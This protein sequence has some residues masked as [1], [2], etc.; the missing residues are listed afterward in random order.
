MY[1]IFRGANYSVTPSYWLLAV[2]M[3]PPNIY[4]KFHIYEQSKISFTNLWTGT[5]CTLHF[6]FWLVPIILIIILLSPN[7]YDNDNAPGTNYKNLISHCRVN[8]IVLEVCQ[9]I[10]ETKTYGPG[11]EVI[12]NTSQGATAHSLK[13]VI[14]D[15]FLIPVEHILVAK[16][17]PKKHEWL[18]IKEQQKV[19]LL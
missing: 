5:I 11:Q 8:H 7:N 9:R 10:P 15:A 4:I 12:W 2:T 19:W 16:H 17:F 14:A 13:Q 18:I 1:L 3:P 6:A